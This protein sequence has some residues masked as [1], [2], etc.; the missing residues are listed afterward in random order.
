[1]VGR[2]AL[3][4][5]RKQGTPAGRWVL[6]RWIDGRHRVVPLGAAD[7]V[8]EANGDQVLSFE[9]AEAKARAMLDRPAAATGRLTVRQAMWTATSLSSVIRVS[10]SWT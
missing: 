4:Y 3:G 10:R 5:V 1:V 7:D 2:A 9:Q 6:R 8:I